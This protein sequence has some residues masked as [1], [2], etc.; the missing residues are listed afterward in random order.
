MKANARPVVALFLGRRV[1]FRVAWRPRARQEGSDL[2]EA[3]LEC[4]ADLESEIRARYG[5]VAV[6]KYPSEG[7]RTKPS[8]T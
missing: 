6:E 5:S 1:L 2:Y 8:A 4:V 7:P 3:L